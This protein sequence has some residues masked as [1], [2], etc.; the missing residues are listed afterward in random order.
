M[1]QMASSNIIVQSIVDDQKHGRVLSLFVMARRGIESL[2]SLLFG[3]I[4]S[5]IGTPKTLMIGGAVCLLAVAA[6]AAKLPSIRRASRSFDKDTAR[7]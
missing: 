7:S 6:F 4:A 5:W 2:G 3:I 1:L